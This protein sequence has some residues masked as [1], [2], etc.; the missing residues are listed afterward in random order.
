MLW[1]RVYIPIALFPALV[2]PS[3]VPRALAGG[4][5]TTVLYQVRANAINISTQR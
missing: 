2:S 3:A 4:L 1:S 5:S